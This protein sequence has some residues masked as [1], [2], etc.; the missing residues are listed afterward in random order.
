MPLVW[1]KLVV[2]EEGKQTLT[3]VNNLSLTFGRL[4]KK[5]KLA[6]R[7]RN[8]Y[9]LRRVFET[10]AGASMDHGAVNVV[11]GHDDGSMANVYRQGV[12]DERLIAVVNFVRAWFLGKTPA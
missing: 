2:R 3:G 10:I 4:L 12:S 5:L 9:S 8:F 1:G 6:K 11:M 7:D